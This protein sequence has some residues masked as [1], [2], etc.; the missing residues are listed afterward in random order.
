[1]LVNSDHQCTVTLRSG[2]KLGFS[3]EPDLR[4]KLL[5]KH[6]RNTTGNF[7]NNCHRVKRAVKKDAEPTRQAI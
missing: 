7:C 2:I 1:M 3:G 6:V 5:S 4:C